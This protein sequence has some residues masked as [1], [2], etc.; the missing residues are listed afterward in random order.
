MKLNLGRLVVSLFCLFLLRPALVRGE[1]LQVEFGERGLQSIMYNGRNLLADG[2][3]TVTRVVMSDRYRDFHDEPAELAYG[4]D[5]RT[6]TEADVEVL[7]RAFDPETATL[8]QTHAWGEL[9]ATYEQ[10]GNHLDVAIEVVNGSDQVIELVELKLMRLD[11]DEAPEKDR[12]SSM[13]RFHSDTNLGGYDVQRARHGAHQLVYVSTEPTQPLRQRFEGSD[14]RVTL[15]VSA[16][17]E[18]GGREVYHGVWNSMSIPSG[19]SETYRLSLRLADRDADTYALVED[20]WRAFGEA[21]PPTFDWRDRRPIGEMHVADGRR[22]REN[23]RGWLQVTHDSGFPAATDENYPAYFRRSLLG[24]A[25]TVIDVARRLGLQG[26]IV[27]QIEGMQEVGHS[28]YGEPRILPYVAPEMDAIADEYFQKFRDAGLRVGVTLRP[29]IQIPFDPEEGEHGGPI[30]GVVTWDRMREAAIAADW[31]VQFR[32]VDWLPEL[33]E[34]VLGVYDPQEA[35]CV[36][37]RLDN[38]IRYARDRWDATIFYLDYN[39]FSRPRDLSQEDGGWQRLLISAELRGELQQRH[40]DVLIIDEHQYPQLFAHGGQYAHPPGWETYTGPD[41]RAAYPWA[42]TTVKVTDHR[43]ILD[44][45]EPF[46]NAVIEGDVLF[47]HAWFAG[48]LKMIREVYGRA[49]EHAPF[50]VRVD[51]DTI[52]I[53]DQQLADAPALGAYLEQ[54]IDPDAAFVDRRT[55]IQHEPGVSMAE[56]RRVVDAVIDAGGVVAWTQPVYTQGNK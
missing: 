24:Q 12:V 31:S 43:V 33:P 26:L 20:I 25:D 37:T 35:W 16:G 55:F 14:E 48:D 42:M 15:S 1:E 13:F 5:D 2:A 46:I 34:E 30:R 23:P 32:N 9:R 39:A 50:H 18:R 51:E 11:L 45:V 3:I 47:A 27:W 53:D 29:V 49:V 8:T 10:R 19:E 6:F 52:E 44:N 54:A 7:E 40:P 17:H 56:V 21:Y 36:L 4:G 38:K 28:Y 41:V 22:N